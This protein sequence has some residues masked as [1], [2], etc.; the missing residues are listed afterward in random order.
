MKLE[1][2]KPGT[3]LQKSGINS[4]VSSINGNYIYT[5]KL[6]SPNKIE[7][8]TIYITDLLEYKA[9]INNGDGNPVEYE[10]IEI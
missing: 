2:I 9:V 7:P 1:N 4:I 6:L 10:N 5:L 8:E 3:T